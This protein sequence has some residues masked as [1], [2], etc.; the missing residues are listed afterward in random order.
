MIPVFNNI[1]FISTNKNVKVYSVTENVLKE[2]MYTAVNRQYERTIPGIH[3]EINMI[4][5]SMQDVI[6]SYGVHK[7]IAYSKP[8]SNIFMHDVF[9]IL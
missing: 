2:W 3:T 7:A 9:E 6:P 4:W 8:M 1:P 5:H